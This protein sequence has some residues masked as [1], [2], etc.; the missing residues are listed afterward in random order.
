MH[1]LF[2]CISYVGGGRMKKEH[3][4]TRLE[5][6]VF[7]FQIVMAVLTPLLAYAGITAADI[8]TW[9]KLGAL[10]L[11]ALSNPYILGMTLVSAWSAITDPTSLKKKGV[12]N[13]DTEGEET[14]E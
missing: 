2:I 13:V 7:V 3:W 12:T 10:L 5:N 1:L 4:I 9:P 14:S 8:T 11:E 6:P